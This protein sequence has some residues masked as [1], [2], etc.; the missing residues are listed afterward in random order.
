MHCN[1][2]VIFVFLVE[3]KF[4]HISQGGLELL[5]ANDSS[6]L[7]SQGAVITDVSHHALL[8]VVI[9]RKSVAHF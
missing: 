8:K 5:T 2:Q 7:A 3:M 1:T 6:I 4:H 9:L